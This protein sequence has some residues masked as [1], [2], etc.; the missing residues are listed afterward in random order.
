VKLVCLNFSSSNNSHDAAHERPVESLPEVKGHLL[1]KKI[2]SFDRNTHKHTETL[3]K[4][5]PLESWG[6]EQSS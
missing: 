6:K 1:V 2:L 3:T 5:A 4:L